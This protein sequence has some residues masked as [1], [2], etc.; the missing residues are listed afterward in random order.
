LPRVKSSLPMNAA[1]LLFRSC[2]FAVL[3]AGTAAFA[4]STPIRIEQTVEP[5]FPVALAL[6][7]IL[8][9]EARV[10]INVDDTGNLADLLVTSYSDKAFADEAVSMLKQWRYTAATVDGKPVGVRM[11]LQFEFSAKG[12]VISLNVF[13]TVNTLFDKMGIRTVVT[14]VCRADEL[15]QALAA[16]RLVSPPKPAGQ[17]GARRSV[18]IDFYVDDKGQP[19]MPVVLDSPSAVYA[20]AAVDALGQW[21]FS[22]P[23]RGGHPVAVRA[24]QEFVFN[25]GS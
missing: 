22:A 17:D 18:V 19:R 24:R 11:E 7:P 20:Q 12:R 5:R 10:I 1:R 3:A 21:R 16:V 14:K 4:T 2:Q 9:G 15:D 13:D 6:S 25:D 23:T 8:T